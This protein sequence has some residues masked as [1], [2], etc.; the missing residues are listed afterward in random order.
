MPTRRSLYNNIDS[1]LAP[2]GWQNMTRRSRIDYIH[3]MHISHTISHPSCKNKLCM[4]RIAFYWD[5]KLATTSKA[6]Q[7]RRLQISSASRFMDFSTAQNIFADF[8]SRLRSDQS[9]W[10]RTRSS[11][12]NHPEYD[13]SNQSCT[14][15]IY[16]IDRPPIRSAQI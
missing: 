9:L 3:H 11:E 14:K 7:F 16:L 4:C 10:S 2:A 12:S 8:W 15:T 1:T 13:W 6:L 5:V